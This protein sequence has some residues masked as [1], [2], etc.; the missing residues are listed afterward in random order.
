MIKVVVLYYSREGTTRRMAN[1]IARGVES[2][3]KC[4]AIVRT[5][6]EITAVNAEAFRI[7][8]HK[9]SSAPYLTHNELRDA[10]ALIVG[11]PTRF[12]NMAAPLKAFFDS[13]TE[14]WLSGALC[15]KP[16]AV[17]TSSGSMHGGQESTLLTM[18]LPLI[19]HGM[20]MVGLPYTEPALSL[21]ES[22]GSPYGAGHVSG[23]GNNPILTTDEKKLCTLLGNRVA[24]LA[25]KLAN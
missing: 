9:E 5:V 20:L 17:F 4:Q 2:T 11:S 14:I 1:Q 23:T 18:M 21:T 25:A 10:D 19:H 12:G 13:T 22:G 16:A 15:D 3:T 8:E 24:T 7:S 6:P